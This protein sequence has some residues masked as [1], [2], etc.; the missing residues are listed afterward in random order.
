MSHDGTVTFSRTSNEDAHG[1]RCVTITVKVGRRRVALVE[2]TPHDFGMALTGL[3]EVPAT[4]TAG[5]LSERN[6]H[7]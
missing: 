2:L 4:I 3:S 1:G 6:D 5:M 7:E